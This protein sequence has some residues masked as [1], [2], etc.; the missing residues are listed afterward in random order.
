MAAQTI[1]GRL[2]EY[3][4]IQELLARYSQCSYVGATY[5]I[6]PNKSLRVLR[7]VLYVYN[8]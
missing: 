8:E 3:V 4:A 2:M 1:K 5:M 7:K 6:E